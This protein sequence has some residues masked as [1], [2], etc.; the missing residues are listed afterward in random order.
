[1]GRTAQKLSAPKSDLSTS[2]VI[3]NLI[4]D[5]DSHDLALHNNDSTLI[6]HTNTPGMLQNVGSKLAHKL[7][8]LVI[9]LD[10]KR[11][12]KVQKLDKYNFRILSILPGEL[13]TSL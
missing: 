10:L 8:I 7:A 3:T 2:R 4:K 5:D 1:M 12:T 11:I 6:V 13:V 9:N